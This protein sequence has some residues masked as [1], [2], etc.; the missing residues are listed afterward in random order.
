MRLLLT[1]LAF[2]LLLACSGE[3]RSGEVPYV[4]QVRTIQASPAGDSCLLVG[5]VLSSPN[6]RVVACGFVV[7]NDTLVKRVV[8]SDTTWQFTAV[9]DSL[10]VG[11]YRV[12]AY[13]VNGVGTSEATDTLPFTIAP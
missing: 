13:A 10:A 12:I 11:N 2:G 5:R 7:L 9:I 6:S 8:S 3:D 1:L 4:P